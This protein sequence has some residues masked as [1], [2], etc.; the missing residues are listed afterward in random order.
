MA[1]AGPSLTSHLIGRP[2]ETKREPLC[3][4][5]RGST[6]G[7][8]DRMLIGLDAAR[9]SRRPQPSPESR[10]DMAAGSRVTR[11]WTPRSNGL[12]ERSVI[13]RPN[14]SIGMIRA[15]SDAPAG[16]CK[17]SCQSGSVVWSSQGG[18][19]RVST[20]QERRAA[21]D[22]ARTHHVSRLGPGRTE[23]PGPVLC[24]MEWFCKAIRRDARYHWDAG[25]PP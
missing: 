4:G 20:I 22:G 14:S 24:G 17:R 6:P 10:S 18:I 12:S 3:S 11:S 13:T 19:G 5:H 25:E 2:S 1:L 15:A 9:S 16:G 7:L 8:G 23:C 21:P